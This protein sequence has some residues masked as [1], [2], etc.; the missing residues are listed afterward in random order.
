MNSVTLCTGISCKIASD[1]LR[2]I[3]EGGDYD[4][5]FETPPVEE[6]GFSCG[7]FI[8][9]FCP[10]CMLKADCNHK[11]EKE[12]PVV[13]HDIQEDLDYKK[14]LMEV[15]FQIGDSTPHTPM[16]DIQ[17]FK[18]LSE[19]EKDVVNDEYCKFLEKNRKRWD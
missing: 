7:S 3:E 2:A 8:Q 17:I 1:C 10:K 15:L 4:D 19:K 12:K 5:Y 14:V 16:K 9:Y 13:L 18:N 6:D 11:C